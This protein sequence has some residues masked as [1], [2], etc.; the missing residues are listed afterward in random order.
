MWPLWVATT[1][2]AAPAATMASRSALSAGEV[3]AVVG[4]DLHDPAV[5]RPRVLG[6]HGERRRLGD[7]ATGVG[8]V[9]V[10]HLVGLGGGRQVGDVEAEAV[11][12]P[13]GEVGVHVDEAAE[14]P[15]HHAEHL[16]LATSSKV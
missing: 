10:A 2:A 16:H 5:G 8:R 15:L 3:G 1:W 12:D 13:G 7:A 4:E 9:G 14:H 11:G 6:D